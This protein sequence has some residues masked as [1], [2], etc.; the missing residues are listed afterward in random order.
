[1]GVSPQLQVIEIPPGWIVSPTPGRIPPAFPASPAYRLAQRRRQLRLPAPSAGGSR[2]LRASRPPPEQ[3]RGPWPAARGCGTTRSLAGRTLAGAGAV[4][5][6][7][8]S[9]AE[10]VSAARREASELGCGRCAPAAEPPLRRARPPFPAPLANAGRARSRLEPS[11]ARRLPQPL[12]GG[13]RPSAAKEGEACREPAAPARSPPPCASR[14]LG[15]S[16]ASFPP[17]ESPGPR[18]AA[19]P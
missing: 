8:R 9:A 11:V 14:G 19:S 5:G 13:S 16:S 6:D 7:Q 17:L 1:M 10:V 12:A 4:R 2:A 15:P 18:A 3:S